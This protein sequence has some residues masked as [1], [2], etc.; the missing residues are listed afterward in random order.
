MVKRRA[1]PVK[2]GSSKFPKS[3]KE[4][5]HERI[6]DPR[7]THQ[8]GDVP[9]VSP[10][11]GP[12][13]DPKPVEVE[14]DA[15]DNE[16]WND[17]FDEE[18]IDEDDTPKS[19]GS[20]TGMEVD[21]GPGG[22]PVARAG[23]GSTSTSGANGTGETPVSMNV[24][25]ELGIFT[26]TRT[27]ILPLKFYCSF[28]KLRNT[29]SN[30][31]LKIRMNAPYNI[32]D[33][34]TFIQHTEGAT[35]SPGLGT[36]QR[37]I[38]EDPNE[39]TF[40]GFDTALYPAV[41]PDALTSGSGVVA[42]ANC[43]P[44]WRLWYEQFYK[45]YHTIETQYKITFTNPETT[46]GNRA[47]VIVEHDV[48][49]ANSLANIMP[50]GATITRRDMLQNGWKHL[51]EHIV[52]ERNNNDDRGW[53]KTVEGTWR[54]GVWDRETLNDTDIKAWYTTSAQPDPD[55]VENLVIVGFNDDF[56]SVFNFGHLNI[57]V[58]LRY[59]VQFKN[60][61]ERVRYPV[62]GTNI[63]PKVTNWPTDI[64]QTPQT[65][66]PWGGTT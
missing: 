3:G 61:T 66:P 36:I 8:L 65:N 22:K 56:N 15:T 55:W 14:V 18:M 28:S 34:S 60:L 64:L 63:T 13:T 27:A 16:G 49:T 6:T 26:E 44:A 38:Y 37:R 33:D 40:S 20:G 24:P 4:E 25:R 45:S 30:N 12:L 23:E 54:P 29:V 2:V 43:R 57:M 19:S 52:T 62:S 31:V 42:D 50:T 53:I 32:L 5:F 46:P 1:R 9:R 51:D 35:V 59:I 47:R 11:K 10:A 7:F 17:E 48:Y 41:P 39:T 21:S 58:E